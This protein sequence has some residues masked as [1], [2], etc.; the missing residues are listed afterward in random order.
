[1][2]IKN[3]SVNGYP[4]V[5]NAMELLV[6]GEVF[7]LNGYFSDFSWTTGSQSDWVKSIDKL[8]RPTTTNP[9]N[10]SPEGSFTYNMANLPIIN[11]WF[12]SRFNK[13]NFILRYYV[14]GNPAGESMSIAIEGA[15][16]DTN[17]N[18]GGQ[19]RSATTGV[20]SFKAVYIGYL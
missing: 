13:Y 18:T 11:Q 8:G 16:I 12:N 7:G 6:D 20:L 5:F 1:M 3:V 14:V 17:S 2:A 19:G 15:C 9:I 10:N 4:T